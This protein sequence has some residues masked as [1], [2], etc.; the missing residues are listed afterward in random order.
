MVGW[1]SNGTITFQDV[2]C[3]NN[4]AVES[5]GCF[6]GAGGG[7]LNNKTVMKDNNA[8]TGGCLYERCMFRSVFLSETIVTTL[9]T[10]RMK[11]N[12][13]VQIGQLCVNRRQ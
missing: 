4:T 12:P 5:G 3:M 8:Y 9:G 1:F 6:Y 13:I 7:M 10:F 11:I 2:A